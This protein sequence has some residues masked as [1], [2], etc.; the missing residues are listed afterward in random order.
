MHRTRAQVRDFLLSINFVSNIS[1]PS[2]RETFILLC[3]DLLWPNLKPSFF[4]LLLVSFVKHDLN[5]SAEVFMGRNLEPP[6]T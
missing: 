3:V 5:E 6:Q 4:D 2:V 1:S